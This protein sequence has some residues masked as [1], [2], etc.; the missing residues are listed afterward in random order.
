[1]PP[2]D[3]APAPVDALLD[4]TTSGRSGEVVADGSGD[5]T[6]SGRAGPA[7]IRLR[8]DESIVETEPPPFR[9]VPE[10][11]PSDVDLARLGVLGGVM[12]VAGLVGA[13]RLRRW[14]RSRHED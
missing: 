10:P 6:A 12:A 3:D 7:S 5:A 8:A 13:W 9:V 4:G 14:L 11:A 2:A 1:V